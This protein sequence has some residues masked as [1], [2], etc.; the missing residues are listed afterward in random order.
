MGSPIQ[1]DY[2]GAGRR[3][4]DCRGGFGCQHS[5]H[6]ARLQERNRAATAGGTQLRGGR[7]A[8]LLRATSCKRHVY[9]SGG[10]MVGRCAPHDRSATAI[11]GKSPCLLRGA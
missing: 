4:G 6:L 5:V 9:S 8:T 3:A 7:K 10:T 1:G 11:L 2:E